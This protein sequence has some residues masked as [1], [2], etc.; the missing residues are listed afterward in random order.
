MGKATIP[1]TMTP[2]T[3]A[4]NMASMVMGQV[5]PRLSASNMV[6]A[7]IAHT[8]VL[9]LVCTRGRACARAAR[10]G[11]RDAAGPTGMSAVSAASS[12]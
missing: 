7:T 10:R 1:A 2:K 9:M 4:A 5:A 8:P 6:A 11:G 12:A 3:K